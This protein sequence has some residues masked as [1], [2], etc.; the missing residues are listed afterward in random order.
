MEFLRVSPFELIARIKCGFYLTKDR[1]VPMR[2][3]RVLLTIVATVA[4]LLFHPATSRS[5]V[6]KSEA[7]ES[8]TGQVTSA[9]EGAMEGVLISAKKQESGLDDFGHGGE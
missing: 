9:E 7:S 3:L 8:L 6:A 2:A 4:V 1:E 5:D